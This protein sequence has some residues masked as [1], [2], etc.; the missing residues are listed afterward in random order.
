MTRRSPLL[1]GST[2]PPASKSL[3]RCRRILARILQKGPSTSQ[4]PRPEPWSCLP[5]Q[6]HR[7]GWHLPTR[8]HDRRAEAY[9]CKAG[10]AWEI[11][12]LVASRRRLLI[13]PFQDL[14]A[15]YEDWHYGHSRISA[16]KQRQRSPARSGSSIDFFW[17]RGAS[18][19]Q[20]QKTYAGDPS[21]PSST[22]RPRRPAT[23]STSRS[24]PIVE[25]RCD[26]LCGGHGLL[27]PAQD[28]VASS[29]DELC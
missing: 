27:S 17:Q 6:L 22:T 9:L 10:A 7:S 18:I 21:D 13:E 4:V 20:L 19:L 5:C 14:P 23:S 24:S 28:R 12:P 25:L 1:L 8:R 26:P 15:E 16:R 11:T 29:S 3:Q 2:Q